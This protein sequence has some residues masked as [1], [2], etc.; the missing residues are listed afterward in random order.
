MSSYTIYGI[1]NCDTVQK[2]VTWLK[3]KNIGFEFHDYKK[4]GISPGKLK[5]WCKQTGWEKLVNKKGTTFRQL[6]DE[7]KNK[8]TN[9][10]AAI[11]LMTEKTSVIKRPVIEKDGKF[12]VLGFDIKEYENLL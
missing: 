1:K 9:E 8:I 10:A 5:E 3:N 12:L 4:E 7:T 6:D 11:A 2:A